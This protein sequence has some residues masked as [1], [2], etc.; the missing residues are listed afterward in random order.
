MY[1]NQLSHFAPAPI[2]FDGHI[3]VTDSTSHDLKWMLF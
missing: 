1:R 3:F 2:I